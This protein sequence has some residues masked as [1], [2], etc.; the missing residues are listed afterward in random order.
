M[1][2]LASEAVQLVG[3]VGA[4]SRPVIII[5]IKHNLLAWFVVISCL[6][7][8]GEFVRTELWLI[9]V[10]PDMV[11]YS[12]FGSNY[13]LL[14]HRCNL[15]EDELQY[16]HIHSIYI[17]I[18]FF[19]QQIKLDHMIQKQRLLMRPRNVREPILC[20]YTNNYSPRGLDERTCSAHHSRFQAAYTVRH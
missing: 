11:N 13:A 10:D 1:C 16:I 7:F 18:S 15:L 17:Y 2:V 6:R 4:W 20:I 12:K 5:I 19:I 9:M 3:P 14:R 8:L